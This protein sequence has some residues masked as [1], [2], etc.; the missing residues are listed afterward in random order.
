MGTFSELCEIDLTNVV[1]VVTRSARKKAQ[2]KDEIVPSLPIN[3]AT[4]IVEQRKD[5]NINRYLDQITAV[6]FAVRQR[7]RIRVRYTIIWQMR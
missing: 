7:F 4:L 1:S 3:R 5:D 2:E 6:F